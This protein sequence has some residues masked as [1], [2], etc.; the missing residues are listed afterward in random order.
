MAEFKVAAH[1]A[2][3]DVQ[4]AVLHAQVINKAIEF[5]HKKG[6]GTVVVPAGEFATGSIYLRSGVTLRLDEGAT[7]KG[8]QDLR[9]YTPL[10]TTA[11]LSRY[12]S[13]LGTANANSASDSIWS[14][15]LIH[16]EDAA[17]VAITG[18]GS[19]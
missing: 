17:N 12:D 7:L 10:R 9:A 14:L 15:A 16:I 19:C 5:C 13:G 6:R 1:G 4:I 2:A 8:V 3:A 11:D 18:R